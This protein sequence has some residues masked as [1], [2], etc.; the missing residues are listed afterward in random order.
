MTS[1]G[2]LPCADTMDI[3]L[4]PIYQPRGPPSDTFRL[5]NQI[6]KLE[7]VERNSS[8]TPQ[9]DDLDINFNIALSPIQDEHVPMAGHHMRRLSSL[10]SYSPSTPT[11]I[12]GDH[13]TF[14]PPRSPYSPR[15]PIL[16]SHPNKLNLTVQIPENKSAFSHAHAQQPISLPQMPTQHMSNLMEYTSNGWVVHPQESVNRTHSMSPSKVEKVALREATHKKRPYD[17]KPKVHS[18]DES[19]NSKFNTGVWSKEEHDNFLIGLENCG[20]CWKKIASDYVPTRDRSQI[21]S[22][23]QKY[24]KKVQSHQKY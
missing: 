16:K 7:F 10:P 24:L 21:A 19:V 2:S 4:E 8:R 15:E 12:A 11:M 22:H 17:K 18:E 13:P 23:A 20:H 3:T 9:H 1:R 6:R 14:K 5:F